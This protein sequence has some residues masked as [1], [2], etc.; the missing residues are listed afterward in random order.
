[1]DDVDSLGT[2][3]CDKVYTNG[4]DRSIYGYVINFSTKTTQDIDFYFESAITIFV[5]V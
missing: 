3:I 1:M 4:A 5:F 2:R